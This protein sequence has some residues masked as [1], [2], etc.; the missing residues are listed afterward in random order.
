MSNSNEWDR[1][2]LVSQVKAA[3]ALLGWSQDQLAEYSCVS[4]QTLKRL[5]ALD[6]M[7][8]GR[9]TTVQNIRLTFEASGIEFL[10]EATGGIGVV[11]RTPKPR[12]GAKAKA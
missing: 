8:G 9:D 11:H 5:E 2:V 6:G 7:L 12:R 3:R 10:N 4:V 1:R